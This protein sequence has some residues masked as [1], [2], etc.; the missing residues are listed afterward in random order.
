MSNELVFAYEIIDLNHVCSV[1][2][3]EAF[4]ASHRSKG[5]TCSAD[6]DSYVLLYCVAQPGVLWRNWC[7]A[8]RLMFSCCI[9]AK[10]YYRDDRFLFEPDPTITTATSANPWM[11]K[12]NAS[13]AKLDYSTGFPYVYGQ[14]MGDKRKRG[15]GFKAMMILWD[16]YGEHVRS[17]PPVRTAGNVVDELMASSAVPLTPIF[18]EPVETIAYQTTAEDVWGLFAPFDLNLWLSIG[19]MVWPARAVNCVHECRYRCCMRAKQE[20]TNARLRPGVAD[21]CDPGFC[22]YPCRKGR[23]R[24]RRNLSAPIAL[25]ARARFVAFV[26][27]MP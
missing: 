25:T 22:D 18:T 21:G 11:V 26:V 20:P 4:R 14:D 16:G 10:D 6:T 24:W 3:V 19:A 5:P 17:T 23:A 12:R 1:E 27:Y 15:D 2:L 8:A 13:A 7:A 9:T